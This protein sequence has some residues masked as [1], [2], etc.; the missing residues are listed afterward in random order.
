MNANNQMDNRYKD[1][2]FISAKVNPGLKLVI[3]RYYQ[4]IY[5]CAVVGEP[6]RKHFAYFERELIP[7][8][9]IKE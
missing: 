9:I 6:K 1:G 2:T 7:P 5:Y 8:V 3:K 4:R